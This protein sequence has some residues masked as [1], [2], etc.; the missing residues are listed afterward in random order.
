MY[1]R[2]HDHDHG[3][4][5]YGTERKIHC[6]TNERGITEQKRR[7]THKNERITHKKFFFTTFDLAHFEL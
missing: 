3:T 5:W 6:I 2:V 7:I 1:R 4:K